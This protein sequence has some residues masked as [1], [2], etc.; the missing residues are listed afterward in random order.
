M[1]VNMLNEAMLLA[2]LLSLYTFEVVLGAGGIKGFAHIG[3]LMALEKLGVR[4]KRLTGISVGCFVA[5][6]YT[7]GYTTAQI[8]AIFLERLA[9]RYDLTMLLKGMTPSDPWGFS[10]GGWL[11]LKPLIEEFVTFYKLL[12]NE[13]LRIL[14][15]D[16]F[17][18]TLVEFTGTDYDLAAAM[19]AS[20]A[21]EGV[22]RP[23][24]ITLPN[25]QSIS[26]FGLLLWMALGRFNSLALATDGAHYHYNPTEGCE[27]PVIVSALLPATELPKEFLFWWD[28]FLSW[29]EIHPE[30]AIAAGHRTVD[31]KNHILV[32]SGL[33]DASALNFNISQAK[34]EKLIEAGFDNAMREVPAGVLRLLA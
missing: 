8:R 2:Q 9:K 25:R 10:I 26:L 22:F 20:C 1:E 4:I 19:T 6:L 12:P 5:A 28:I 31:T 24:W 23:V 16:H 21:A 14:A 17:R 13:R 15:H 33:P 11:D 32:E 18:K 27:G 29:R 34:C 30:L 7:N 3:L